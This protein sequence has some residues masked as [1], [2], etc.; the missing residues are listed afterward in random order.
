MV[1]PLHV[2]LPA[3]PSVVAVVRRRVSVWLARWGWPAEEL[4]DLVLAVSEAVSNSV[5][6]AYRGDH[7]GD[8]TVEGRVVPRP[9]GFSRVEL[10]VTDTGRWRAVPEHHE[11]RRH[12]IPV[13]RAVAAELSITADG[14]GTRVRLIS[15]PV[16]SEM[17][18]P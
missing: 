2:R 4:G 13:M 5:E 7:D 16:R 15:N 11:N 9:H 10:T 3:E 12:G 6:H 17:G 18:G 1:A 14:R 8:V